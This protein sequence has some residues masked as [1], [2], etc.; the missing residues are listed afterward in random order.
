MILKAI[1]LLKSVYGWFI[2]SCLFLWDYIGSEKHTF[3]IVFVCV[4]FDLFWG[5]WSSVRRK[6]FILSEALR[7]TPKKLFI[8]LSCLLIIYLIEI[9][10]H[11][12]YLLGT[13]IVGTLMA[14]C[15]LWSASAHILIIKPDMPFIKLFRKQLKGE[16]EK[17][18]GFNLD[19]VLTEKNSNENEN[20]N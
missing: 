5:I 4:L 12:E 11:D 13:K 20:I 6:K 9:N 15:E 10:I 18:T 14:A 7:E 1:D 19:E 16:M 3:V 2:A 17:K 8:Y